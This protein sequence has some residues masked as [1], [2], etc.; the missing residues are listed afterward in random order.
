MI[1]L[2]RLKDKP[3]TDQRP[4]GSKK[5]RIGQSILT[6]EISVWSG[7]NAKGGYA[8]TVIFFLTVLAVCL[9]VFLRESGVGRP[10]AAAGALL[11]ACLPA[12][13]RLSLDGFLSQIGIL[14]IFP[15]FF[16]P[17]AASGVKSREALRSLLA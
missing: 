7:T 14:F 10:L 12:V 2:G 6:A 13:T 11:G 5:Q 1:R 17:A 15:L 4:Q 8:A 16:Q 9:F 3:E